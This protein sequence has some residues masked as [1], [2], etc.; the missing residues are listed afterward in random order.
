MSP[1]QHWYHDLSHP[2]ALISPLVPH[3]DAPETE[4][5]NMF[6][7]RADRHS[8]ALK[9]PSSTAFPSAHLPHTLPPYLPPSFPH[10]NALAIAPL[11]VVLVVPS[12]A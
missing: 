2:P 1:P 4:T 6:L 11:L 5:R 12:K 10:F 7:N 8:H 3:S 9:L